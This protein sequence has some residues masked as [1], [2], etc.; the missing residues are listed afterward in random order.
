M[1]LSSEKLLVDNIKF[2]KKSILYVC[3]RSCLRILFNIECQADPS[4][5]LDL[6]HEGKPICHSGQ[7]PRQLS[8]IR[9]EQLGFQKLMQGIPMDCSLPGSSVHGIFQARILEWAAISF[10]RGSSWP[11]DRTQVSRIIGRRF[12]VWA[13]RE[14]LRRTLFLT[15]RSKR[16]CFPV[17][18]SAT[19]NIFTC[20]CK[21]NT[22]K[23]SFSYFYSA[24]FEVPKSTEG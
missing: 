10:S 4:N 6:A 23:C 24:I 7:Q 3:W 20:I 17:L 14:V 9:N 22:T 16:S 2:I 21:A 5:Q 15:L 18:L 13:T 1:E 12:T 8:L 19:V 11:R